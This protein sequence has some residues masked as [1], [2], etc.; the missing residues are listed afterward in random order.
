MDDYVVS[1]LS[2]VG[3]ISFLALSDY[4]LLLTG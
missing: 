1:V 2:N 3:M 4:L